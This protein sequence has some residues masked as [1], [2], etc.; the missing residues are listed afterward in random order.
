MIEFEAFDPGSFEPD[1]SAVEALDAARAAFESATLEPGGSK[2][3]GAATT[4]PLKKSGGAK[5]AAAVT[6]ALE[7][8]LRRTETAPRE[9]VSAAIAACV[10]ESLWDPVLA[11][12]DAGLVPDS[13]V[14]GGL[15]SAAA[16]ANRLNVAKRFLVRANRVGADDVALCLD[17]FLD[18]DGV[19]EAPAS[20]LRAEARESAEAAVREAEAAARAAKAAAKPRAAARRRRPAT[21]SGG[22]VRADATLGLRA[23]R[24]RRGRGVQRGGVPRGASAP[25]S[26]I[27]AHG[28]GRVRGGAR[29]RVGGERG[30]VCSVPHRV[31][32]GLRRP[33]PGPDRAGAGRA[34]VF[35]RGRRVDVRAHRRAVHRVRDGGGGGGGRAAAATRRRGERRRRSSARA[36]RPG[37]PRARSRTSR[38]AGRYRRTRA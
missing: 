12:I 34:S 19:P 29:G 6:A 38:R 30:G 32:R 36:R 8:Y 20:A 17:A 33:R 22:A 1:R 4:Q 5:R 23:R 28:R 37:G 27:E 14:A 24:R 2:K 16:E 21:R 18:P 13:T 11:L 15:V 7:P 25:R 26:G 3:S 31:A 10:L 35:I 9:F